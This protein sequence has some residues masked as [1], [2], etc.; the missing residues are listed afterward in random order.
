MKP[1]SYVAILR[2]VLSAFIL[3][4]LVGCSTF[5]SP[6]HTAT[7]SDP[8]DSLAGD[9]NLTTFAFG[10]GQSGFST[11]GL[12][13]QPVS[14]TPHPED[15]LALFANCKDGSEHTFK[16]RRNL[17]GRSYLITVKNKEGIS[18]SDF[19][20][21]YT[22]SQGWVGSKEQIVGDKTISVTISIRPIEGRNWYGWTI[23]TLPTADVNVDFKTTKT[24]YLKFD[25]T[26]RK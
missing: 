22:G 4:A 10:G 24:P 13:H 20:L 23:E 5:S 3:A 11:C 7:S 17:D 19:P 12:I 8:L 1:L 15:S 16:L 26:R 25:L 2:C 14:V 6:Q 21:S 9:W 18:V